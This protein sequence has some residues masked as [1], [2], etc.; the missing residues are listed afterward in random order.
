MGSAGLGVVFQGLHRQCG[1]CL[2]DFHVFGFAFAPGSFYRS[3]GRFALR[4]AE[5]FVSAV[6]PRPRLVVDC[7]VLPPS[8]RAIVREQLRAS[9][10]VALFLV[11]GAAIEP[12]ADGNTVARFEIQLCAKPFDEGLHHVRLVERAHVP[13]LAV[14]SAILAFTH[15]SISGSTHATRRCPRRHGCGAWPAAIIT[16]H[17]LRPSPTRPSTPGRRNNRTGAAPAVT[18]HLAC[19]RLRLAHEVRAGCGPGLRPW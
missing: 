11:F 9:V 8:C 10:F 4:W 14:R 5:I 12:L 1:R 13:A 3:P 6:C 17:V 16:Y 2:F 15:S 7:P 19:A 18:G